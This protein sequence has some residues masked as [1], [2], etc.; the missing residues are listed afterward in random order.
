MSRLSCSLTG[1]RLIQVGGGY[2]TVQ[3]K[4]GKRKKKMRASFQFR[5]E[6]IIGSVPWSENWKVTISYLKE[7]AALTL[8][9]GPAHINFYRMCWKRRCDAKTWS[10][11]DEILGHNLWHWNKVSLSP[12]F[13]LAGN[14]VEMTHHILTLLPGSSKSNTASSNEKDQ[15]ESTWKWAQ[16]L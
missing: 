5:A 3:N 7:T 4:S 9:H 11:N 15:P 8:R 14:C 2:S 16:V 12:I 6:E 13:S 10:V 1:D